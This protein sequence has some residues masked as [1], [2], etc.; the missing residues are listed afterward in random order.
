MSNTNTTTT[1]SI[2]ITSSP[3][4]YVGTYGKYAGGSI[5]G[6]WLDLADYSDASEFYAACRK[7]HKGEHDP[8]FMFQDW[9]NIPSGFIHE[10]GFADADDLWEWLDLDEDEQELVALYRDNVDGDASLEKAQER[11][12]GRYDSESDFAEQHAADV[13]VPCYLVIDWQATWNGYLRHKFTA[14]HHKGECWIFSNH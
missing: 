7:L 3:R 12:Y 11:F 1:M 8:E 10:S 9:E 13:E 5:A 6:A 4:V 14:V 2:A